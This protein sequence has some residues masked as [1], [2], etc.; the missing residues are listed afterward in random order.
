MKPPVRIKPEKPIRPGYSGVELTNTELGDLVEAALV[1]RFGWKPLVGRLAGVARQG[2]FDMV[3]ERDMLVEVKAVTV[4]A[5]E[6]KVKTGARANGRKVERAL[7][8]G[9]ASATVMAV[10]YRSPRGKLKCAVY[11]RDGVGCFRLGPSG[12]GW[13]F[14]GKAGL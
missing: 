1:R 13:D 9:R 2:S 8:L 11:R 10:V 4:Y 3:D 5:S 6:Y 7:E 14:V 12:L